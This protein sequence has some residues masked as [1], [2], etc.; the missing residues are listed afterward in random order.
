MDQIFIQGVGY[1]ALLFVV[2]SFQN[3]TRVK[4]LFFML[5][6]I[7][8]FVVHYALLGAWA[9]SLMNLIEA[10]VVFVAYKKETDT[11]AQKR[12]WPYF[13]IAI[14]IAVGALTAKSL[15]DYLPVLAQIFGT[16]AVW[17]TNPRAIRF[18]ML[19]PRPLWLTYNFVV[20]SYAG[21]AAELFILVSVLVGIV[22]F[23][24]LGKSE[25]KS[26]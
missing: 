13:F 3:N 7:L 20:G 18:I 11:W 5:I 8:L 10:A 19:L 4:L 21:T 17:Q 25:K 1:L 16:I 15:V 9:G 26:S 14:F 6:G 22:R 2:L 12:F 23:D 24:I